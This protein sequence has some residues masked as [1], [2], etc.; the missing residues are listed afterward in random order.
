MQPV[1]P[2]RFGCHCQNTAQVSGSY[3]ALML[4][5]PSLL[6]Q[7]HSMRLFMAWISPD[8]SWLRPFLRLGD[9]NASSY[10][11]RELDPSAS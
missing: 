3:C 4:T 11:T 10:F 8:L 5:Y 7:A 1:F 2:W 6:W 9:T